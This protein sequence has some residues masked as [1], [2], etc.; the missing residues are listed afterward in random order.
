MNFYGTFQV[1]SVPTVVVNFGAA[2]L[3]DILA[4]VSI[5]GGTFKK[6]SGSD[7]ISE[8]GNGYYSLRL[9]MA[10]TKK[11]ALLFIRFSKSGYPDVSIVVQIDNMV[12]KVARNTDQSVRDLNSKMDGKFAELDART[13]GLVRDQMGTNLA[14]ISRHLRRKVKG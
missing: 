10:E 14:E 4:Q 2:G 3:I 7:Y 12:D 8:V 13:T 9:G 1:G 6:A 11:V 5:D